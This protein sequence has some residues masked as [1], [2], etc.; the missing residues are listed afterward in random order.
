LENL[1]VSGDIN[2]AWKNIREC[3][4]ILAKDG[5]GHYKVKLQEVSKFVDQMKQAKLQW[6][7]RNKKWE[8]L[9]CQIKELETNSR[10]RNIGDLEAYCTYLYEG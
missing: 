6:L 9:K 5:L 4:K 2:R 7:I 10:N 8:Y 3:I 1:D